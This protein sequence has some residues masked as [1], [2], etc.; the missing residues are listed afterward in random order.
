MFNSLK[1]KAQAMSNEFMKELVNIPKLEKKDMHIF[2]FEAGTKKFDTK[3]AAS[4]LNFHFGIASNSQEPILSQRETL[5]FDGNNKFS[6]VM[7]KF[8]IKDNLLS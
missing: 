4:H 3:N 8:K 1:D 5:G 6:H 7:L 2:K